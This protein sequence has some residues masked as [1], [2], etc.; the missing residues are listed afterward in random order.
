[1]SFCWSGTM[2]IENRAPKTERDSPPA[3]IFK[4]V[5]EMSYPKSIANPAVT[6]STLSTIPPAFRERILNAMGMYRAGAKKQAVIEKHGSIVAAESITE[7]NR[8]D[9]K[10]WCR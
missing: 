1:M 8:A 9:P 2:G 5:P 6:N 3:S 7:L 4:D 10:W